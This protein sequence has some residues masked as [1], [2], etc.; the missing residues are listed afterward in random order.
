[1]VV[2]VYTDA[3]FNHKK[4]I[5]S[6]GFIILV[7]RKII[8]HQVLLVK[9]LKTPH[10]AE[11]YSIY[12]ALCNSYLVKGVSC[13]NVYCDCIKALDICNQSNEERIKWD[14]NKTKKYT[15]LISDFNNLMD[16]LKE[17]KII[18]RFYKVRAHANNFFNNMVDRSCLNN[19]RE[20]INSL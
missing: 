12:E 9:N 13:I 2:S 15:I 4:D 14:Y 6:C 1:M 17:E 3:S 8:K 18:T 5:S 7:N 16:L 11:L 20:Y 19:L 10:G